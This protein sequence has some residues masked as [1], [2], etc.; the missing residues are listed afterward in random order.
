[1]LTLYMG[2][3]VSATQI[4]HQSRYTI[5]FCVT[6]LAYFL[7]AIDLLSLKS[8]FTACV[9]LQFTGSSGRDTSGQI[10]CR[11]GAS[12]SWR[13]LHP[14]SGAAHKYCACHAV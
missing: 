7:A 8:A 10:H 5:T 4:S 14:C 9:A 2:K 1:M 11:D 13:D 6:A 12:A 3:M